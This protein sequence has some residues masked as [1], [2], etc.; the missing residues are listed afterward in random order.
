MG[1]VGQAGAVGNTVLTGLR[2]WSNSYLELI[3]CHA[4]PIQRMI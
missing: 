1:Q 4:N 3:V 2:R